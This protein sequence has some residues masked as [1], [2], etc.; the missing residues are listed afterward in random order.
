MNKAIESTGIN[1]QLEMWKGVKDDIDSSIE[2]LNNGLEPGV[3]CT[4][5]QV[6]FDRIYNTVCGHITQRLTFTAVFLGII[7]S[8]I[9]VMM[10]S[11]LCVH[12]KLQP[13]KTVTKKNFDFVSTNEKDLGQNVNLDGMNL[14]IKDD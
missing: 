12:R 6:G 1:K 10:I 4:I 7:F 3:N 5:L 8:L 9:L 2:T 14:E 11:M 13:I